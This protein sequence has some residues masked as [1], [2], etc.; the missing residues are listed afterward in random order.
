[1]ESGNMAVHT[2]RHDSCHRSRGNRTMTEYEVN[3]AF[4][5]R[6]EKQGKYKDALDSLRLAATQTND[7]GELAQLDLWKND[8]K[9]WRQNN[10]DN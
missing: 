2:L 10:E 9:N 8:L 1:M 7:P 4:A 6:R 3:L 5:A